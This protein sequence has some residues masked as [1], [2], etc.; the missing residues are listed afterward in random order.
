MLISFTFNSLK[1]LT[2]IRQR[3]FLWLLLSTLTLISA[4]GTNNANAYNYS[5]KPENLGHSDTASSH[6][7]INILSSYLIQ[8][9]NINSFP[10]VEL[11]DLAW[12]EDEQLLYSISDEGFLYHLKL[13][14]KNDSLSHVKIVAAMPLLDQQKQALKGKFSDSE[15]LTLVNGNNGKRGDS[16]LIISFENKPRIAKFSSNG[17]FLSKIKTVKKLRKR[18]YFRAK[19]KALESV[20]LHPHYG[21]L[22]ASEKPLKAKPLNQQTVYSSTGKEWHFA[23]SKV[24]NSSITA[25][26]ILSKDK[27]LILERAYNGLL[28]PVV[29]SLRQL[30]F[31]KC[32]KNSFC[33]TENLARLDTSE[34]WILDN[35]EGLTHFRDNQ[36]LMVSDNNNNPLQKTFLVLFEVLDK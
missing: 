24:K 11:S 3:L 34:G 2:F 28:S 21:V 15:G 18:K 12:D 36:Y 20:A 14:I 32:D 16:E 8:S 35:F 33:E 22:T 27:L 9:K 29:I 5:I 26:E 19:N 31:N 13:N 4:C 1:P 6:S 7:R 30:N 10:I 23:A 25:L 17:Q